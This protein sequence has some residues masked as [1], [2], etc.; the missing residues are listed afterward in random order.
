M[1]FD[2][3][4]ELVKSRLTEIFE[5]NA[6]IQLDIF[7]RES[8]IDILRQDLKERIAQFKSY[9]CIVSK[10]ECEDIPS[11][12]VQ[13]LHASNVEQFRERIAKISD[14]VNYLRE[15]I[16]TID[17]LIASYNTEVVKM[18]PELITIVES[19]RH[20]LKP[21]DTREG[22]RRQDRPEPTNCEVTSQ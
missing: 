19:A 18:N 16:K 17:G 15:A 2:Q 3:L 10:L 9:L 14:T 5:S 8:S 12:S 4:G 13:E 22:R 7:Y 11:I 1:S 20:L 21:T 6:H